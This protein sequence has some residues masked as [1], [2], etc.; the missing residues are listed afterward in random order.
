MK[1]FEE[2]GTNQIPRGE[3]VRRVGESV[4]SMHQS[5]TLVLNFRETLVTTT[6]NTTAAFHSTQPTVLPLK[7]ESF[8]GS[9]FGVDGGLD[10]CAQILGFERLRVALDGAAVFADEK[11]LEVPGDVRSAERLPAHSSAA[12]DD[13][14]A[15]LFVARHRQCRLQPS[16]NRLLVFAIHV[17]TLE[18]S[19]LGLVAMARSNVL[20][21]GQDFCAPP[22]LLSTE[23]VA[24]ESEHDERL[25]ELLRQFGHLSVVSRR[26]ASHGGY[27]FDQHDLSRE[28]LK[29][30]GASQQQLAAEFV[31]RFL[32]FFFFSRTTSNNCASPT[33]GQ[34]SFPPASVIQL[35]RVRTP[36]EAS[37]APV[38]L[39]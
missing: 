35:I 16:E 38:P 31:Q 10:V 18:Q 3:S 27:V 19:E 7:S 8:P 22:V 13:R 28:R 4:K 36:A 20:E 12:S 21:R 23:L 37:N 15:G 34:S 29:V 2:S 24:G 26:R 11:L 33:L 14:G 17:P 39:K 32:I 30:E 6:A 1:A 5:E 9:Q 25:T